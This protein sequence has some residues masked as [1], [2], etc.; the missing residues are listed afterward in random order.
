[1]LFARLL[2]RFVTEGELTIHDAL[3]TT[4]RLGDPGRGPRVT[5]RFHDRILPWRLLLNPRLR[6]G[7]AY[8]DGTLTVE[9]G[10]IY[11]LL[12]LLL[13]NLG[14]RSAGWLDR[15][16]ERLRLLWRRLMQINGV[17]QAR[18]NV[19]HHYDLSGSLYDLFLDRDRQYSCAYFPEPGCDLEQAQLAKKRHIAAKLL[20]E[21][22]Q[23][24]LD[25]GSGW[26]G[27]A[28]YLAETAQ[29][30]VT[31][32][33]LSEEQLA[34][35]RA[36]AARAGLDRQV[37]FALRDYRQQSGRFDRIVSVGMFEHVGLPNY[38]G[39]FRKVAELLSDDGVALIHSIAQRDPPCPTNPWLARY[40]FPGGYTPSLS[41]ILPPIEAAGLWVTDLEVLRLHYAE[42]LRRWRQRFLANWDR[43]AQL[44]DERFCRMWEFYLSGSELAFRHQGHM[45]VQIQVA[46]S[47]DRVP[48]TRDYI[49]RWERAHAGAGLLGGDLK[50]ARG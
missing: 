3:G 21:P 20:L 37:H 17:A 15:A 43:A 41:E 1:M 19:A 44:Y 49:E 18:R 36:R 25:I 28:L 27:L 50:V 4:H 48:L 40:I 32:I 38:P 33:T 9:G 46:K 23:E 2:R 13:R 42:T 7:E 29:A 34:H 6:L 35:A 12:D 22:G 24:V 14:N 39:F 26:G 5:I 16:Q 47:V 8:M 11:D 30:R 45:V 10:R 31:G